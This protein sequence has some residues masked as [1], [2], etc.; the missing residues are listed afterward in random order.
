MSYVILNGKLVARDKAH[1]SI[2]DRG[3]RYGDG[4]FETIRIHNGV[5]YRFSWHLQRLAAGL[6][7]I[8][9][10]YKVAGLQPDCA[11]LIKRNKCKDGLLRIQVTRGSGGHGYLPAK[12]APTCVIET[13]PLTPAPKKPVSLWLSGYRRIPENALPVRAK[14]CQGLNSTLARLEAEENQCFEALQLNQQGTIA[15]TS[16]AHIFWRRQNA[17]FT[18]A[19]DCGVLEGSTR[20]ALCRLATPV[21]TIHAGLDDLKAADAVCITNVSWGVLPVASLAPEGASWDSAALA[22]QLATLLKGDMENHCRAHVKEW[23]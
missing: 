4:V 6:A 12:A 3:F 17:L 21:H 9:L 1:I 23:A 15:E 10:K 11:N 16:S 8:R 18:P 22:G 20:N 2:L 5:P 13:L 14:L 7:A 19:L